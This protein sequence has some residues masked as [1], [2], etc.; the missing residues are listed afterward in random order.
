MRSHEACAIAGHALGRRPQS[1]GPVCRPLFVAFL[2]QAAEGRWMFRKSAAQ[3]NLG[4]EGAGGGVDRAPRLTS[5]ITFAWLPRCTIGVR[6]GSTA[7]DL[8]DLGLL[9]EF[10]VAGTTRSEFKL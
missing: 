6:N 7:A 4:R 5:G 9:P 3:L 8:L 10:C 2:F 1:R